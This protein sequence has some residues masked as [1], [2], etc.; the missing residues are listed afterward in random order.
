MD[1]MLLEIMRIFNVK[2]HETLM[3]GDSI[4]DLQMAYSAGVD[5]IGL[6]AYHKNTFELQSVGALQ[7]FDNLHC[8]SE[9]VQQTINIIEENIVSSI[10]GV[11]D[12]SSLFSSLLFIFR[13]RFSKIFII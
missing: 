10:R 9:T 11:L 1:D 6:D 4:A 7:V 3:I 2:A 13:I 12:F 8:L 5:A